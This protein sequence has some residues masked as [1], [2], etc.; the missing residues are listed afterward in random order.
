MHSSINLDHLCVHYEMREFLIYWR[1]LT[2][3][4]DAAIPATKE[5]I[6]NESPDSDG[7]FKVDLETRSEYSSSVSGSVL[8]DVYRAPPT[9]KMIRMED[10]R[11]EIVWEDSLLQTSTTIGGPWKDVA[12][13]GGTLHWTIWPSDSEPS[14][15]FRLKP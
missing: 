13:G 14:K 11:L 1:D 12:F 4:I 5:L 2:D 8:I 7:F 9:I 6:K 3:P 15:F 10:G